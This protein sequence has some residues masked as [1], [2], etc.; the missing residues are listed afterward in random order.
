MRRND[1]E[2]T[3]KDAIAAFLSAEQILRVAFYDNGDI[4]IVPVNYGYCE[5]NGRIC[6]Y[7]QRPD[8]NIRWRRKIRASDL[9]L[10]ADMR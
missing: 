5:E 7:F 1:R 4:Y 2:I 10:T 6:F 8:G 3:D 9:K